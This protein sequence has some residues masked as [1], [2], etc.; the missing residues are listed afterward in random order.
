MLDKVLLDIGNRM[1]GCD[2]DIGSF[3]S[4]NATIGSYNTSIWISSQ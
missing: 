1:I 3:G 2:H 4:I